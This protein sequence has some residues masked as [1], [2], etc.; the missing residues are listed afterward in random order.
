MMMAVPSRVAE[1]DEQLHDLRLRRDVQR[2]GGLV[3]DQQLRIPGQRDRDHHPLA[4]AAGELVR[5]L[6]ETALRGR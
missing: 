1:L 4:H 2:G 3:G 5:V 6:V